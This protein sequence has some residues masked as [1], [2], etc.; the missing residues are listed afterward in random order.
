MRVFNLAGEELFGTEA[1]DLIAFHGITVHKPVGLRQGEY[2]WAVTI[3]REGE[4][5]ACTIV[6]GLLEDGSLAVGQ[7]VAWAWTDNMGD[8]DEILGKNYPTDWQDQADLGWL[9][10]QANIGLAFGQHG[11]YHDPY[12]PGP[13]RLWVRDKLRWSVRLTG[14][15]MLGMTNHRTMYPT[16]QIRQWAGDE[17]EPPNGKLDEILAVAKDNNAL[18]VEIKGMLTTQPPPPPPP[19]P[20]PEPP[21]ETFTVKYFNNTTLSGTPV[22]TTTQKPPFWNDWG[23]GSPHSSVNVDNFSGR[24][25]GRFTFAARTYTF[26]VKADD[27]IRL[28]V[29]GKLVIDKWHDQAPTIYS[30]KVPMTAGMHEVKIEWYERTGGATLHANWQ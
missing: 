1:L 20:P 30:V 22:W 24:W 7:E 11:W 2:Y 26:N 23:S 27:G 8:A 25:V 12:K 21:E 5:P 18:L 16:F 10:D 6:T 19:P 17:E 15:G 28:W 3:L 4:G 14:I 9:N 13:G 29:A